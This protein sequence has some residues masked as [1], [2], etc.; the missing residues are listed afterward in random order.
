V[1]GADEPTVIDV[2]NGAERYDVVVGRALS[3]RVPALLPGADTVAVVRPDAL[4]ALAEP[5]LAALRDAGR[6]AVVVPLPD[7]EQAK[8]VDTL[9]SL[10]R[11]FGEAAV[12]RSDAVVAVGGGAVTDV[13]GFAAASWLRGVRVVHVPTTLLGMVDAAVGGKTAVNTEAGKNLVGAFHPPAGVVVDLDVL[14]TLPAAEWVNG[15]AEVVKAG[16]IDDPVILDLVDAD[17]AACASPDG[18]HTRELVERSIRMKAAVVTTDLR[19]SGR[20]EMLNYGH[21]L[22]HAL[23]R[24]EEFRMPHGHAVSIGLVFAAALGERAGRTDPAL[25]ARHRRLLDAVGLPTRYA[26]DAWPRLYD[27]MRLDKK[28][29]GDRLRFVV[30][31]GLARP[32]ILEAP[33]RKLLE[34]AYT[35]VAA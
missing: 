3:D 16:F 13:A 29:R 25:A 4:A 34:Q 21:T 32:G 18:P 15:M 17:P 24:V 35:E 22:G 9:A 10:W 14:A 6:E 8:T 11:A 23:E 19:E 26:A 27:A 33:S 1:T 20:R 2:G 28:A 7:G 30:L 5:V 31:D 12:T